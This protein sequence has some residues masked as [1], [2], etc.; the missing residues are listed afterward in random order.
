M[1]DATPAAGFAYA[2][3]TTST[4]STSSGSRLPDSDSS[5][6]TRRWCLPCCGA[7]SMVPEVRVRGQAA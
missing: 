2:D 1:H 5:W 6:I 4:P 7:R 3:P